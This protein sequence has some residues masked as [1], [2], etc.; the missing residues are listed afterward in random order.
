MKTSKIIAL[1]FIFVVFAFIHVFLQTEIIKLGYQVKK[2]GDRAQELVDNNNILKYNIYALE[3]PFSLDKYVSSKSPNLRTIKP[4][5]VLS[6]YSES[7]IKYL[8]KDK[9]NTFLFNNQI[10]L[11]LKKFFS[12]KQA[13]ARAIK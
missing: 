8:E 12:S 7:K 9:K 3:S 5:Q 1:I 11:A 4:I 2:N 6:L 13:E 10:F